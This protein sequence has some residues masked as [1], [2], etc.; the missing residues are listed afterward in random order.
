MREPMV[1]SKNANR[2]KADPPFMLPAMKEAVKRTLVLS[3]HFPL[4]AAGFVSLRRMALM[5]LFPISSVCP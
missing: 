1:V 4:N 2:Q 5:P 3:R